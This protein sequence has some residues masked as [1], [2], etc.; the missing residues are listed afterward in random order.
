[1]EI[2]MSSAS[3]RCYARNQLLFRDSQ[4]SAYVHQA[5][6]VA[7]VAMR[8][9]WDYSA[10]PSSANFAFRARWNHC[11]ATLSPFCGHLSCCCACRRAWPISAFRESYR[12]WRTESILRRRTR[13][14]GVF[15]MICGNY[16]AAQRDGT[17]AIATG[18]FTTI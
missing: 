5:S 13:Y 15:A 9:A 4:A 11:F 3:S 7:S 14:C 10:A 17:M 8:S 18:A 2:K 1:M 6:N 12:Y 16:I